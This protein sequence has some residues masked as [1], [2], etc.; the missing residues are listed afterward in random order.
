MRIGGTA[1]S[2][3]RRDHANDIHRIDDGSD[4]RDPFQPV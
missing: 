2:G 4:M 3:R 1:Q